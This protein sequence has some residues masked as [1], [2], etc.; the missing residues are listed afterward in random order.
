MGSNK[1]REIQIFLLLYFGIFLA[2]CNLASDTRLKVGTNVWIGYRPL[3]YAREE[4]VISGKDLKLIEYGSTTEVLRALRN[5]NLDGAGVT[6]DEFFLLA[7]EGYK[8]KIVAVVDESVGGDSVIF[9]KGLKSSKG[10]SLGVEEGVLGAY[11]LTRFSE[12]MNIPIENFKIVNLEFNQHEEAFRQ[13]QV[14]GVVTFEPVKSRLLALGGETV[15]DS[16]Q[17][18]GEIFDL[19]VFREDV[20]KDHPDKVQKI[21]SAWLEMVEPFENNKVY[22]EQ[23]NYTKSMQGIKLLGLSENQLRFTSGKEDFVGKSKKVASFLRGRGLIQRDITV[24]PF[25]MNDF[26]L[27]HRRKL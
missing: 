23:H 19:L 9:R 24:E 13:R 2:G 4:K 22:L 3:Y 15:F 18:P 8:L 7:S 10:L 16:S 27:S 21:V 26:V 25:I 1:I 20:I 17:I 6:L 5:G 12:K 14:D 11:V